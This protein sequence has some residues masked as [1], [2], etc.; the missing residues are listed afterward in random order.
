MHWETGQ[1]CVFLGS[2]CYDITVAPCPVPSQGWAWPCLL[3]L[4]QH[5]PTPS[6]P[7][8]SLSKDCQRS[9]TCPWPQGGVRGAGVN[10]VLSD[11]SSHCEI[12]VVEADSPTWPQL[13]SED[14]WGL[15]GC[16]CW[17]RD[18]VMH[19][20]HG[21]TWRRRDQGATERDRLTEL[22]ESEWQELWDHREGWASD[23]R[24]AGGHW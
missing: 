24:T 8:R 2:H 5:H 20:T 11:S 23:L 3:A 6:Y 7:G 10:Q 18:E 19:S 9:A 15:M 14:R 17:Q 16:S 21:C 13:V 22:M 12:P 4:P 1:R